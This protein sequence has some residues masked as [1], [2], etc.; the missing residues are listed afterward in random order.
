MRIFISIDAEGLPGI[1]HVVQTGPRYFMFSE[2][3][4]IA[5]RVA[6]T[7]AEELHRLGSEEVWIA[8]S[9]WFMGNIVYEEMPRYVK[10][11]R[12]SLRPLSMV[13]CID[14]G[15]DA[16]MFLGYHSAAGTQASVLEHTY[17]GVAFFEVRVNGEK[18]SEYLLNAL[19]AGEFGVPVILVMGDDKLREDVEKHTPWAVYIEVKE[20]LS[21]YAAIMDSIEVALDKLR[22]GI[23]EAVERLRKGE[24]KPL[25]TEGEITVDFVF[26]RSGYADAASLLPFVERVD[27]YTVRFRT[28]KPSEAYRLMQALAYIV[29]GFEASIAALAR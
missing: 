15:F 13:C 8:D 26:R 12:G 7:A 1:F 5:T 19:V 16:A 10:L 17:S 11:V 20:S 29:S 27:A 2:L 6:R 14:R 22:K 9:H 28:K 18:A 4:S 25:K 3:R 24:A 23:R 21:R